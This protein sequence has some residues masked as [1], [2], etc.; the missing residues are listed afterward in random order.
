MDATRPGN[1]GPDSR[2]PGVPDMRIAVTESIAADRLTAF[3]GRFSDQPLT[4]DVDRIPP[5]FLM[6]DPRIRPG[7]T[8]VGLTPRIG[9]PGLRPHLV[10][11]VGTDFGDHR[12]RLEAH[13]VGT[14]QV[15]VSRTRPTARFARTTDADRNRMVSGCRSLSA[16]LRRVGTWMVPLTGLARELSHR[17]AARRGCE[18]LPAGVL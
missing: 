17:R 7:G 13:G 15:R 14:G 9:R 11:A 1:G 8:S 5:A 16:V 2:G 18:S 6:D 10:G 4:H 12:G 3:P